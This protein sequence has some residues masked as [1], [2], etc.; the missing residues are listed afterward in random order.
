MTVLCWLCLRKVMSLTG[1]GN[2]VISGNNAFWNSEVFPEIWLIP[3]Q[4]ELRSLFWKWNK[5]WSPLVG[6]LQIL[7]VGPIT[8]LDV[9]WN[10]WLHY[11]RHFYLQNHHWAPGKQRRNFICPFLLLMQTLKGQEIGLREC[12]P[13]CGNVKSDWNC[14][15]LEGVSWIHTG[16]L[17]LMLFH[18]FRLLPFRQEYSRDRFHLEG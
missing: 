18:I 9:I 10:S 17:L 12:V 6:Q 5:A 3:W 14:T 2:T 8:P 11:S 15:D 13:G 4:L 7:V 1:Y 16:R